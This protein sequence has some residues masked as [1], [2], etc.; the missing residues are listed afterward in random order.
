ML[1]QPGKLTLW[2]D[3]D[4][5]L[6][7]SMALVYAVAGH[8][9]GLYLLTLDNFPGW[10]SGVILTAHTMVIC[11]YLVHESAHMTLFKSHKRICF[12]FAGTAVTYSAP[13]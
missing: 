9:L 5:A 8:M 4:G 1:L 10:I 6:P 7:N 2:R 11:A 12:V 13:S 3:P